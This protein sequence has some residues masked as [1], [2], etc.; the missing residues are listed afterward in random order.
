MVLDVVV[1]ALVPVIRTPRFASCDGVTS[2]NVNVLAFVVVVVKFIA[3]GD[4]INVDPS[5]SCTSIFEYRD[6][7]LTYVHTRTATCSTVAG[8]LPISAIT[9]NPDRL[10][11]PTAWDAAEVHFA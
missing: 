8:V 10:I 6:V 5:R 1:V 7:L 2:V 11:E 9:P 4:P 3:C